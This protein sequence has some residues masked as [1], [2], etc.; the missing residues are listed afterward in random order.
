[1]DDANA[2]EVDEQMLE[3]TLLVVHVEEC[4]VP[5]DAVKTHETL[6]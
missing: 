1:M 2:V 5:V 4:A 6:C 3:Q